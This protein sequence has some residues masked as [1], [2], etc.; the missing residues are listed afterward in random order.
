MLPVHLLA[1]GHIHEAR[2]EATLDLFGKGR[3]DTRQRRTMRRDG[4]LRAESVQVSRPGTASQAGAGAHG[5]HRI[6]VGTS[7][8]IRFLR[9]DGHAFAP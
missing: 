1:C 9:F 3:L 4:L 5:V 2:P 8:S 6:E 7:V